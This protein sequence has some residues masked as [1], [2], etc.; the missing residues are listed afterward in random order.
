MSTHNELRHGELE[1]VH[2]RLEVEDL[3]LPQ[4]QAAL[5]NLT[6]RLQRLSEPRGT[7]DLMREL[8]ERRQR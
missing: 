7:A 3:T 5:L 1:D 8:N 4:L 6:E 2:Y